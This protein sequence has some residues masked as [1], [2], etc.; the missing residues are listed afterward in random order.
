MQSTGT[1]AR[2]RLLDRVRLEL[3]R[4]HYSARTERAYLG[5]IRRFVFFTGAKT[6]QDLETTADVAVK[7]FLDHLALDKGASLATRKQAQAALQF[8][9]QWVLVREAGAAEGIVP[10]RAGGRLPIVLSA[11]EGA[12]ILDT[13]KG[14]PRLMAALLYGSGLRLMECARL[15]VKDIDLQRRTIVVRRGDG[16]EDRVVPLPARLV[17]SLDKHLDFVRRVYE[18]D[19]KTNAGWVALPLA[20]EETHETMGR[21]WPW[22]WLFPATRQHADRVTGRLRR[23]HLHETVLQKSVQEAAKIC[24]L[25]KRVTPRSLRHSF[26]THL[27]ETGTDLRSIQELLGHRSV[28]TTMIYTRVV[29]SAGG[30]GRGTADSVDR[31]LEDLTARGWR[32]P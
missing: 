25:E 12:E 3:A 5:W 24:G 26:A 23:H 8:L 28:S 13:M 31:L 15:R 16:R 11:E 17:P 27:L 22:Q 32:Y 29:G 20:L 21:S 4:R 14:V 7:G 10:A 6:W 1:S 9:F 18:A 19:L 30:R 2:G